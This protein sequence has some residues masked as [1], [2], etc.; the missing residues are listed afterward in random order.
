MQHET[1]QKTKKNTDQV[2][3]RMIGVFSVKAP[4]GPNQI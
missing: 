2:Q 4:L 3:N 1:A